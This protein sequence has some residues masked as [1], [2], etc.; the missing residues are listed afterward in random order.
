MQAMQ[1]EMDAPD[2]PATILPVTTVISFKA[3]GRVALPRDRRCPRYTFD[4]SRRRLRGS[5]TLP[6]TPE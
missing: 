2:N 4:S 6:A 1:F 3:W 5:A